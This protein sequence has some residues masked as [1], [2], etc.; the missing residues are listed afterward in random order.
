MSSYYIGDLIYIGM[1]YVIK[2]VDHQFCSKI[3]WKTKYH[4]SK[5]L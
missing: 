4:T 3:K 2:L 5:I 1:F